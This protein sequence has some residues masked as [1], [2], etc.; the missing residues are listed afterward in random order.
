MARRALRSPHASAPHHWTFRVTD[1][2][3]LPVVRGMI[4][5]LD[6]ELLQIMAQRMVLVAEVAAYKRAHG[7]RIRDA[8]RER[9]LI[10]DRRSRADALGLPAGEIESIFR[11]L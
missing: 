7:I 8:E 5:A 4:D 6:R 9:T 11:V 1:P 3:P 2:R 10:E